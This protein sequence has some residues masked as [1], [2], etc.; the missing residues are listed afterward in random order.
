MIDEIDQECALPRES[1]VRLCYSQ[2]RV[3]KSLNGEMVL[4]HVNIRNDVPP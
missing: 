3:L 4:V 1:E 2:R